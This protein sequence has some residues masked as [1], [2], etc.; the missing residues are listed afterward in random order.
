MPQASFIAH[1][2]TADGWTALVTVTRKRVRNLNLRVHADGSVALSIPW[3]TSPNTAQDFLDRK[4][5]WIRERVERRAAQAKETLVPSTGSHAGTLPLWGEL[6]DA[7]KVLGLEKQSELGALSP[8]ELQAR[9][10]AL[11]RQEVVRTLPA[12]VARIEA[13]MG[14][15]AIRWSVRC[16]K[17]RWGSCTPKTRAIRI[18]SALA[19]YPPACL[20]YVVTHELTHLLEPSHN[21]RFH[22][23]LNRFCPSNRESA[24]ILK[25]PA[26]EVC[27]R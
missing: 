24:A 4:A 5:D 8:D 17:T 15:H 23:L 10:D 13:P 1:V 21:T 18:N 9:I 7:A 16:M 25:R 12:V 26:R 20:D 2:R 27:R 22:A 3:R 6:A 14:I 19:A 11:Y